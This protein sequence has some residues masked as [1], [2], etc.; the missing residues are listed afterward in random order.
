MRRTYQSWLSVVF[1]T[2]LFTWS[3][4][5]IRQFRSRQR[6]HRY[7]YRD[8]KHSPP[9]TPRPVFIFL[10]H[11]R[12]RQLPTKKECVLNP[13]PVVGG[14]NIHFS[15]FHTCVQEFLGPAPFHWPSFK[16]GEQESWPGRCWRSRVCFFIHLFIWC[17]FFDFNFSHEPFNFSTSRTIF[18]DNL[19]IPHTFVSS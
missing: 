6:P 7:C 3:G 2:F 4:L 13:P 19:L 12:C 14:R 10:Y 9:H 8:P 15:R 18:N 5:V 1:L 16:L 17:F 11:S